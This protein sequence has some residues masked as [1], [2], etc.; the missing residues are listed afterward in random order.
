MIG[1]VGNA[2]VSNYSRAL[3]SDFAPKLPSLHY[4]KEGCLRHQIIIAKQPKLTQ[5]G[6]FS[7]RGRPHTVEVGIEITYRTPSNASVP[8]AAA[9][10]EKVPA[11]RDDD[12]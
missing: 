3:G 5:T 9:F 11:V 12:S 8:S 7:F 4:R 10:S 2:S 1:V 6:W